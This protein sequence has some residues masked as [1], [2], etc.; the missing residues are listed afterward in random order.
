MKMYETSDVFLFFRV[1]IIA[2]VVYLHKVFKYL[3]KNKTLIAACLQKLG[4][5]NKRNWNTSA[6]KYST[7]CE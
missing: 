4:L 5:Q 3:T 7:N 2:K 1:G 6:A